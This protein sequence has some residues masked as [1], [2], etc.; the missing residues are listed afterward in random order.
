MSER[1]FRRYV[2]RYEDAGE[3]G[4]RDRRMGRVSPRRPGFFAR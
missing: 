3:E 2:V 4:V 1:M